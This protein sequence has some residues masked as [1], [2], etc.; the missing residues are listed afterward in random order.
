VLGRLIPDA[1][2]G[3]RMTLDARRARTA[4]SGLAANLGLSLLAAAEGVV[5]V[6]NAEM[7]RAMRR[8]SVERGYDP[9]DYTLVAFGGAGGLH[10][11]ELAA[12]IGIHRVLLPFQPGLLSAWGAL[13]AELQRDYVQTVRLVDADPSQLERRLD[14]LRARARADLRAEG[15]APRR[16]K[17]DALIDVRYRGQSYEIQL[18][19]TK[20]YV[21]AFHAEHRRLYGYADEDR[22]VE[23][24]NVR[25]VASVPSSMRPRPRAD[26]RRQAPRPHR[27]RWQG[28]WLSSRVYDRDSM[29]IGRHASGPLL[30]TEFSA[31]AVVPP[32]WSVV[33]TRQGDLIVERKG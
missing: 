22:R 32:G 18:P 8:I 28:R 3:G 12:E 17:I 26:R 5:R 20:R 24:V 33:R 19:M 15:A 4:L 23:V 30:I 13:S 6:V 27:F 2:L 31:T 16:A 29:E 25:V 9:R 11:C 10:A 7:E 21:H 14:A 1:F